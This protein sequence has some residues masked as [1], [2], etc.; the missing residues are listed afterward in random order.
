M[1]DKLKVT[2]NRYN[3]PIY[4]DYISP[5]LEVGK[6]YECSADIEFD[7]VEVRKLSLW[8]RFKRQMLRMIGSSKDER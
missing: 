5:P 4:R 7:S 3:N 6:M 8:E 2:Y 1:T